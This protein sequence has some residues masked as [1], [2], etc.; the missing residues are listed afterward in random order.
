MKKFLHEGAEAKIYFSDGTVI[1][2]R[3]SKDYRYKDLDMSIRKKNT[4]KEVKLLQKAAEHIPVPKVLTH[5]DK[6]MTIQMEHIEGKKLRDVI[7]S[8]DRKDTFRR[9]GKKIAKLHNAH[10]IHGDLTTSNILIHDKIY[11][12]DFGLGFVSTKIEDKAVDLHII[13]K[14]LES[15]HYLHAEEC[16][17]Y[18]LEG[19]T[20]ENKDVEMILRRLEKVE[21]RGHYKHK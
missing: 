21:K 2:E 13:K 16:F 19:Y 9:V 8:I 7:D 10:I 20:K 1:K 17:H 4:R 11:F 14:A 15:K 18:L 12:I 6:T 3:L 5:S